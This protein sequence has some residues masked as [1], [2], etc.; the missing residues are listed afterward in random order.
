MQVFIILLILLAV[1]CIVCGP[2]ALIISII[3]LNKTKRGSESRGDKR[4]AG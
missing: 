4:E 1:G 3:A 2:V